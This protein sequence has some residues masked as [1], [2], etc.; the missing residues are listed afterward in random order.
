[1]TEFCVSMFGLYDHIT[2]PCQHA[3]IYCFSMIF[4]S[5]LQRPSARPTHFIAVRTHAP[6]IVD[7]AQR[8]VTHVINKSPELAVCAIRECCCELCTTFLGI[9]R[10]LDVS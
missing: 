2:W 5:R 9:K 3:R 8:V 10:R 7:T 4:V 6:H 1:M